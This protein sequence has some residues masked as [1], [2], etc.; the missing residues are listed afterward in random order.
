MRKFFAVVAVLSV[1]L[2]S[3]SGAVENGFTSL[4]DGQT[5][6]GWTLIGKRGEGYGVKSGLIYC[7]KGGGGR[8]MT[9]KEYGNF[10]LRFEFKLD[11]GSNNGIGIR[12]PLDGDSA[13][14]GME[15]QVLDDY[16]SRYAALRPAQY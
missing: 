12:A 4:F 15:I 1:A 10:I 3:D 8:L 5:L 9:E 11:E 13:Y 6:K 14:T 7:A 16:A 2:C